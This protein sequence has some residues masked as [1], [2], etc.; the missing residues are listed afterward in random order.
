MKK[1]RNTLIPVF[2]LFLLA[3]LG[4]GVFYY[5][6]VSRVEGDVTTDA[7]LAE[8][9]A[10][11]PVT[12][13]VT[14]PD[15]TPD[16]QLLYLGSWDAA[17]VAL[18][19]AGDGTHRVT[20]ELINGV[21]YGYKVTRG[22]WGTVERGADDTDLDD[23]LIE[24]DGS[25]EV[26]LAV[27]AWIDRGR[28]DPNRVTLTGDIRHHRALPAEGL[29]L[30]HDVIVWLPPQYEQ[31]P[32]ARFPVLYMH[33]GQNLFDQ[34][35]SYQGV[36]WGLDE[37]ATEL[38]Q[39]E[40]V[41]PFIVVGLGNTDNRTQEFTPGSDTHAAYADFVVDKVKP[42][43]DRTYRTAGSAD[44]TTLGGAGL[45]ALASLAIV[46]R[47]PGVFGQVIGL[48]PL[49]WGAE[50]AMLEPIDFGDGWSDV[51]IYLDSPELAAQ[52]ESAGLRVTVD[53]AGDGPQNEATWSQQMPDLLRQ[54]YA[55][56]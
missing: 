6:N 25:Q 21:Q 8:A 32:Q 14:A 44:D 49:Q 27:A 17:G 53:P 56:D 24:A 43:I 54:V 40:S 20:V 33:D 55:R 12:F 51:R 50:P 9:T 29:E 1:A 46:D 41:R 35:T 34:A 23:R 30:P 42:L 39:D 7:E 2:V 31:Q 13:V 16:G 28:S 11:V 19:P 36:E 3:M 10:K 5:S 48:A 47:H 26:Q 18:E 52:L 37:T 4:I 22:T 38:A 45:G 15:T